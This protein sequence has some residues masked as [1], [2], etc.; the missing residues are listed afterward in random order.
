MNSMLGEQQ[1]L[2][3][4]CLYRM[5]SGTAISLGHSCFGRTENSIHNICSYV[6]KS[7]KIYLKHKNLGS[8]LRVGAYAAH[9]ECC[10]PF[11]CS[12]PLLRSLH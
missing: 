4:V 7:E 3:L 1:Q 10:C 11:F 12:T 5:R 6:R 2:R 8:C 9:P